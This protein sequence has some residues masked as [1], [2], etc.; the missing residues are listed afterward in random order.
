[1]VLISRLLYL[2]KY[3]VS[4][5]KVIIA[6]RGDLA[7][8]VVQSTKDVQVLNY[9]K[10]SLGF[11]R[12]VLQSSNKNTHRFCVQDIK[13]LFIICL[14]FI[15]ISGN[16]TLQPI[17]CYFLDFYFEYS[18]CFIPA[19]FYTKPDRQKD[20]IIKENTGRAGIYR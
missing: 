18:M 9:I 2:Y 4:V 6:K 20:S 12:V 14:L 11:G 8:T 5:V 10:D 3:L 15:F 13:N 16:I 1:M 7:F 17:S 19:V